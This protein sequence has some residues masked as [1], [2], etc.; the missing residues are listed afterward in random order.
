M[1]L[2]LQLT[3]AIVG[4]TLRNRADNQLR[5]ELYNSLEKYAANNSDIVREW[6]RLQQQWSCCGVSNWDD[7]KERAEMDD[8]PTSCCPNNDCS[9]VKENTTAYFDQDCYQSVRSLFFRYSRALGGVSIFF[10]FVEIAG[11]MSAIALLR[12]LKNN[13][14]NV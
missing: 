6:N 3:A 5:E 13:C 12:D 14:G 11:I 4:F 1:I 2:L 9:T 8:P 7:W 10:F